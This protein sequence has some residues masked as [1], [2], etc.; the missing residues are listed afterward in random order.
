MRRPFIRARELGHI[1]QL[2]PWHSTRR[3]SVGRYEGRQVEI[4]RILGPL[5][6]AGISTRRLRRLSEELYG[7][8]V[9]AT[10]ILQTTAHLAEEL[11]Q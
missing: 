9:R 5:F 6:L 11:E 2:L 7:R 3:T 1:D 4:D 10:T 8:R